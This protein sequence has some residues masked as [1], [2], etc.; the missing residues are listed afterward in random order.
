MSWKKIRKVYYP[1]ET[2]NMATLHMN[3]K[4]LHKCSWV[5][6]VV[7]HPNNKQEGVVNVSYNPIVYVGKNLPWFCNKRWRTWCEQCRMR[8]IPVSL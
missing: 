5:M 7:F 4:F 3:T 8:N 2:S 1:S 6:T